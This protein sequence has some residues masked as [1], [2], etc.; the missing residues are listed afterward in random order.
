MVAG[1]KPM[2]NGLPVAGVVA[3]WEL[4]QDFGE[5]VP[6]FNTFGGGNA[7]IAAAHQVLDIVKDTAVL[8]N[9]A[10]QGRR[11]RGEM[12]QI[13]ARCEWQT[14]VRGAGLY[15]G[16]EF[17]R[18]DERLTPDPVIAGAVVDGMREEGVLISAAGPYGN[19]LKIRPPLV[20]D[21]VDSDRFLSSFERVVRSLRA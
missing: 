3:Q 9:V 1:A 12:E 7:C 4:F 6:Y 17:S 20:F 15:I 8:S 16:V 21:D 19:V 11:L 13:L 18:D 2:A 10:A 5:R 14:D